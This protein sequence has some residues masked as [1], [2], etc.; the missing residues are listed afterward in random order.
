MTYSISASGTKDEV[1]AMIERDIAPHA[2]AVADAFRKLIYDGIA[3]DR[4]S[5]S[6]SGHD[7]NCSFSLTS[8]TS[9]EAQ[10]GTSG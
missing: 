2:P 5:L 4:V 7:Y 10:G 6:A 3:G 1:A 9:G 8:W